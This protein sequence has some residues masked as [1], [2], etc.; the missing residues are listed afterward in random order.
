MGRD[1]IMT[2][3]FRRTAALPR[4]PLAVLGL[5]LALVIG[6]RIADSVVSPPGPV[7]ALPTA[8]EPGDVAEVI[9]G[10]LAA[11]AVDTST[12]ELGRI[13]AN[14]TFWG[15]RLAANPRDFV[16]ATRVAASF[17][18]LARATGDVSAYVAADD[19]VDR[20]LAVNPESA[21]ARGYR[22]VVLAALHRFTDARDHAVAV[23]ADQP[24]DPTALATLGDAALELGD[25]TAAAEA[26]A[27]LR[28]VA[29]SAAA[30]VRTSRL[31]FIQGRTVDAVA[32][33]R[34]AVDLAVEEGASGGALAW[35]RYQLGA[36]LL[37]TGDRAGGAEALDAALRDDPRSHLALAG[38]ARIAAAD[39]RLDAA[40]ADLDAAI[41]AIPLPEALAR[42]ADLFELRGASG[43]AARAAD[44]RAT[45][46]AIGQL[47]GAGSAVYD[48]T[49]SLY[50][51]STGIDPARALRLAEEE[52]AVRQDVYGYDALGWALL[53]N[54]RAPDAD[55]ALT[56][57]L[58]VGT[59]DASV[60]YH[61]GM[62]AAAVGDARRARGLLEDAIALDP[63]FDLVGVARAQRTLA[64]LQ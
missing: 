5:S 38:R 54:G 13:R 48:R 21:A 3:R 19:A 32:A 55:A 22:G 10:P 42:R 40:I 20:A 24:G 60:L 62:A 50:L 46:L 31:A 45:V 57:A 30:E 33:S 52:I 8:V 28:E 16:S 23:L 51:A 41:A 7:A 61:A 44:D 18:D 17:I 2:S 6:P 29:P 27:D 58:A 59:R 49:L 26:Y 64:G 1:T 12:D 43:D 9:A 35:Y 37:G 34:A 56:S 14:V 4:V 39:G 11:P 15:D 36:L 25:L 47:S 63:T 53:A